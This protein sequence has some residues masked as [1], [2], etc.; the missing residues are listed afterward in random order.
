MLDEI[1]II[2]ITVG[3]YCIKYSENNTFTQ[4]IDRLSLSQNN[5]IAYYNKQFNKTYK[6]LNKV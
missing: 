1:I 2:S 5:V 4:P 3:R 6:N